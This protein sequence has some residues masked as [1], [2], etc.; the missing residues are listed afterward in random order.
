VNEAYLLSLL[1]HTHTHARYVR[2]VRRPETV[3]TN[4]IVG[5]K[6]TK[7][8][9]YIREKMARWEKGDKQS[10]YSKNMLCT[11]A[12]FAKLCSSFTKSMPA[13]VHDKG[14]NFPLIFYMHFLRRNC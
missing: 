13:Y 7:V 12:H 6:G 11:I 5:N 8:H 2:M 1:L 9:F 4:N 10:P 3:S 14:K